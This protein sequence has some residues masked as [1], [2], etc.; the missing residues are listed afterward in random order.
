MNNQGPPDK[1]IFN[2]FHLTQQISMRVIV[3]RK[4]HFMQR[5]VSLFGPVALD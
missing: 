1:P 5:I 4:I 3:S 2:S